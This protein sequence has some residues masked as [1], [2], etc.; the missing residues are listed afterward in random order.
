M[1]AF[2]MSF[3]SAVSTVP[4]MLAAAGA[5]AQQFALEGA[6]VDS[7]NGA[8]LGVVTERGELAALFRAQ[9][10]LT[11]GILRSAGVS[12]DQLS[13]EVRARIE[14]FQTTNVDAFRAF[15][16]GLDLKDQGRFAEAREQFRRAAELDPGFALASEQ[17]QA[18]PDVN[19][20]SAVQ[21]RAVLAAAAGAAV[22]RGKAV[23]VVD[24]A[25]AAAAV[26]AGQTVVAVPAADIRDR[27]R[28]LET[29]VPGGS[30]GDSRFVGLA[31][32]VRDGAL[33]LSTILPSEWKGGESG[34]TADGVLQSAGTVGT[35]F[36]ARRGGATV[37]ATGRAVLADGS[38]AYWGAWLSAPG[39]TAQ[40]RSGLGTSARVSQAPELGR[41][42]WVVGE[43]PRVLPTADV[44]FTPRGGSLEAISG[45][46][47]VNGPAQTVSFS[48]LGFRIGSLSFSGLAG[49]ADYRSSTLASGG[50]AGNYTAGSCSGCSGFV[51]NSSVFAGNFVGRE[52]HGL[53]FSTLLLTGEGNTASGVHLFTRP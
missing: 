15:S 8:S 5:S 3:K 6:V 38:V 48:D 16:Q 2:R 52:A 25:R 29:A 20:S 44:V 51:A 28:A 34:L 45:S 9:K 33:S 30:R 11:F 50:F 17:Q 43:A 19:L 41:V 32:T 42:D 31:Y 49:S 21:A 27:A 4:L 46:I 18:M 12:L 47:R 40:V 36:E 24:L 10:T 37:D 13:P 39:A 26:Q 7:R 53:V 23:A 14:R 22:E 35:S 1:K